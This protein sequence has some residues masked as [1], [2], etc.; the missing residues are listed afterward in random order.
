MTAVHRIFGNHRNLLLG[1]TVSPTTTRVSN[2]IRLTSID[3]DGYA[4][5]ALT[6]PYT[7]AADTTIDVEIVDT[8]IGAT[9]IA[10]S[11]AFAG[12]GNGTMVVSNLRSGAVAQTISVVLTD[13]GTVT[14]HAA[15]NFD[16][17][18]LQ[19]KADGADGNSI[20]ISVDRSGL[21]YAASHYSL[22][23]EL[24]AGTDTVSGP[25]YDWDTQPAD[26][27]GNVPDT[28]HRIAFGSDETV[29]RQWKTYADGSWSYHFFP[30]IE[31]NIAAGTPI[32]FV[33]GGRTI[34]VSDGGITPD[35]E[36]YADIVTPYDFVSAVQSTSDLLEVVGVVSPDRQSGGM[37]M[38]E[39]RARTDAHALSS[40]GSGSKYAT[41]LDD[42]VVTSTANTEL[43]QATCWDAATLGQERWKVDGSVSGSLAL[44]LLTNVQFSGGGV[45]FRIPPR[46]PDGYQ[47]GSKGKFYVK[48]VRYASRQVDVDPPPICVH[49]MV[50]GVKA[51]DK[52]ITLVYTQ[53]P[54]EE[55]KCDDAVPIG[56]ISA[57]CL[58]LDFYEDTEM[59]N[60]PGLVARL[61]ALA[62]WYSTFVA[63]NAEIT[64]A[65]ELRSARFD[66][67]LAGLARSEL[68]SC[69]S[70]LYDSGTLSESVWLANHAYAKDAL[71]EPTV[72]NGYRYR[73]TVSGTSHASTQPTWPTTV[74]NTVTDNGVTWKCVSKIPEYAWDDLLSS[75]SSELTAL[76]TLSSEEKSATSYGSY[77]SASPSEGTV[78]TFVASDGAIHRY[79]LLKKTT[80]GSPSGIDQYG[81][82]PTFATGG[83]SRTITSDIVAGTWYVWLDWQDLGPSESADVEATATLAAQPGIAFDPQT[84][85]QKYRAA[86]DVVRSLAGILPKSEAGGRRSACWQDPGDAF[87]WTVNGGEYLPAFTNRI[88]HSCV[89]TKDADGNDEIVSTQEFAFALNVKCDA[90]VEGDTVVL[91][92]G[93]A[94]WPATYQIGDVLTLPVIA[95]TDLYLTGGVDGDDTLHWSVSSSTAGAMAV[96]DLVLAAPTPYVATDFHFLITPGAIPF[97]AGDAFSFALEGGHFKWRRDGGSWS[98]STLLAASQVLADG[99]TL[100]VA[101]GHAPGVATGDTWSWQVSQPY[102]ASQVR[103]PVVGT[104]GHQWI[105]ATQTLA[106][107]L[108]SIVAI[109]ATVVALH[110]L[111]ST[112]TLKLAGSDDNVTF[113]TETFT[114]HSGPMV[115][116]PST[117][118]S[119]RYLELRITA[120]SGARIGWWWVGTPWAPT[121]NA[122][123]IKLTRSYG[124]A[125]G[126]G[127]NPSA[128]YRG[129]GRAGELAWNGRDGDWLEPSDMTEWINLL[130]RSKQYGDEPW[131]LLP[132]VAL[133]A[134]AALVVA[135][136]DEV[137]FEDALCRF[138]DSTTRILSAS[139][140]LRAIYE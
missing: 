87:Y 53:R 93:D 16:E 108:G 12:S 117:A 43:I 115:L 44:D 46:Y 132:N 38:R 14:T 86:C 69:L 91:V 95:A 45:R 85:A 33:S 123:S 94:G 30:A 75:V 136:A 5:V 32:K 125:R 11:P 138:Q 25:E 105:G 76:A 6:G 77:L 131:V 126:D 111:P 39:F 120:A 36:T 42:I 71:V 124:M 41:G 112:A 118:R 31:R 73:C 90:L 63:G 110:S 134:E 67:E 34:T 62:E 101:A 13:T 107:D 102:A 60:T 8:T 7:G 135:D 119:A 100:T 113:W 18:V 114:V 56:H 80:S 37:A 1:K 29:Y 99:L 51:K 74:G 96:Y 10:S 27:A 52:E 66:I 65:G 116:I 81:L 58:G 103:A 15:L 83:I 137:A 23:N 22:L 89:L 68:Y 9:P 4:T 70:D 57:A 17:V 19:A 78:Y 130:D 49:P 72:R 61:Q 64:A 133:L 121:G 3:Q 82:A 128:L 21:T 140:P 122:T 28:A 106:V 97:A 24:S 20:S 84:F 48:E 139:I 79:K 35:I 50:L 54:S 2:D 109:P 59:A 104:V 55:C 47:S 129:V 98:S 92:I 40:T 26:N 127:L 88:Y